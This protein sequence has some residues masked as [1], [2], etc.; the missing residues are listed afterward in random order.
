M[1]T[2]EDNRRDPLG[3]PTI[4]RKKTRDGT[5]SHPPAAA[6]ESVIGRSALVPMAS[7]GGCPSAAALGRLRPVAEGEQ[8]L[9]F[10]PWLTNQELCSWFGQPL[11]PIKLCI[12]SNHDENSYNLRETKTIHG[13]RF[14][15]D[16][17]LAELAQ[18]QE[19]NMACILELV[20][21]GNTGVAERA[22]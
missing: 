18:S 12:M 19:R 2:A 7:R 20:Q 5:Q 11:D 3:S 22:Q 9:P 1:A 15:Q 13:M 8:L 4:A 6:V 16:Q 10:P 17:R 21:Q 14:A